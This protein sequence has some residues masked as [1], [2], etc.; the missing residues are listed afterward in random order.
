MKFFNWLNKKRL[1]IISITMV[2]ALTIFFL[3]IYNEKSSSKITD[4]AYHIVNKYIYEL[5][6]SYFNSDIIAENDWNEIIKTEQ[7][8]EGEILLV[9][10][11]LK[12]A[13]RLNAQITKMLDNSLNHISSEVYTLPNDVT[14][15]PN[16]GLQ[17]N[18]PFFF[19]SNWSLLTNLGPK[20]PVKSEVIGSVKTNIKTNVKNYGI[21]NALVEIYAITTIKVNIITPG[22]TKE[23]TLDYDILLDSK[24]VEG[25]VPYLYG[26]TLT[27]ERTVI[28]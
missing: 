16:R 13:N 1:Y 23:Y 8:N 15:T 5:V 7:N 22:L 28:N 12:Q 4:Y 6:S 21:N 17:F 10:F 3:Q 18:I 20:I 2:F 14:I 9:D 11:D 24:L 25:R 19:A 26:G 27:N